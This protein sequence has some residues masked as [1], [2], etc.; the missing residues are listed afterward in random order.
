MIEFESR[1]HILSLIFGG[2][3]LGWVEKATIEAVVVRQSS[4]REIL[5]THESY[6]LFFPFPLLFPTLVEL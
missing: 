5:P 1:W 4:P 6:Y 2:S 3:I